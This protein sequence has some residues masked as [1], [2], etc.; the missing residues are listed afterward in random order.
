MVSILLLINTQYIDAFFFD[1]L[2]L[3]IEHLLFLETVGTGSY[4]SGLLQ[5]LLHSLLRNF[6]CKMIG[7]TPKLVA[8]ECV[9]I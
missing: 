7:T 8:G 6:L 5:P 9:S 2:F 1:Y 3:Q 4:L